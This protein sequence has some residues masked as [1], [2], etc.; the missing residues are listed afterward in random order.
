MRNLTLKHFKTIQAITKCGKIVSA[1]K[2]LGLSPPALTIQLRQVEE[3]F[4]LALFDRTS[5][6]MRPTAAGRAFVETAQ[7]IEE[8]LGLLEDKMDAIK[9]VRTGSLRLGVVSTAKYFAP[10][11]MA[12]F[13]KDH[14]DIDMRLAIGNRA[15]T[16]DNLR[17]HDIDIALMGRPA[18]EVPVRASVFGDH[19]L[20]IIAPPDHPL[21]A[22]RD[23]SKERIAEEHFLIREP[24]SGTRISLEIF[25]SDV[26]GRIDDL[27]V[28]MASNETI[29][30]AV[31]AGLGIAFISAHTIA[32]E[33]EA[34][35]LVILDVVGMPIRR[36]WFSVMR[37]DHAISPAM[38]TFNDFLMRKG[39][40]YLP[41]FGKL[42]PDKAG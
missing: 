27:G 24:G 11:L 40:M 28:E 1:A 17:N 42:Y 34:G 33:T 6:G 21:V 41:L 38:A 35:R 7:V 18:K 25:L 8:H 4:Q 13:M 5:D 12:A 30:Q 22:A 32:A 29:K 2:M 16:I 36:Q 3:E 37:T 26:P 10:R 15:Q 9:G 39:A 31:M 20:V 23:I 14:P 19:P